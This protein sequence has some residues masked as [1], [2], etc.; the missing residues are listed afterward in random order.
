MNIRCQWTGDDPLMIEYHDLEW[1]VPK[2]DDRRLFEDLILD[3]AHQTCQSSGGSRGGGWGV[4]PELHPLA[5]LPA[6]RSGP[7]VGIFGLHRTH[8]GGRTA[9]VWG[10]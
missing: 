1:G 6:R 7:R 10:L 3:G 2:H 8:F 4:L 9:R 5:A